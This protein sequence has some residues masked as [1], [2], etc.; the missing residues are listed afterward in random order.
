MDIKIAEVKSRKD[1]K[2][3]IY[4]PEKIHKDH[5]N[6]VHPLYID[7]HVFFNPRKNKSFSSTHTVLALAWKGAQPVGR[8][9]GIINPRYNEL[10]NEKNARFCFLEC[11]NDLSIARELVQYI[12]IWARTKGMEK[13]VGPLGFSD[14]DPQGVLYEG[15]EERVLIAT[16]YNFPWM[17]DYLEVLGYEKEVELVSYKVKIPESIPAYIK[18]VYNRVVLNNG[19]IV[20]EFTSKKELRPWIVPIF[21]LV[22]DTY[23]NIYGFIPMSEK[24]MHEYANRYLFVINPRF[25]KVVSNNEKEVIAFLISM[26]ELS[27]GIR[28]ARGRLFPFGWWHILMESRKTRL[29]SMLLGAIHESYRS[30]GLDSILGMKIIESAN[31]AGMEIMDSHLILEHNTKMRAEYER[32]GG[33]VHKRFRI[34]SKAL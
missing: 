29:L 15:F 6:W 10:H 32:I 25:V 28:R 17:K 19:Y 11:Y 24:E 30:K 31:K 7:D 23:K 3:F 22:N 12:E 13:L 2:T 34:F 14:K 26:P 18:R 27:E 1:L 9:M 20:H 21:R 16:N 4:L 33:V 5:S 8:V